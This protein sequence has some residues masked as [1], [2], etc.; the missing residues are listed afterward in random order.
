MDNTVWILERTDSERFPYRVTIKK[1]EEPLLCLLVQDR[2]PGQKGNI[3]CIRAEDTPESI[4]EE[5]ERVPVVSLKRFGK[6][7][8]VVLDRARN[9]RCDFLFLKKRYKTKEG[10]FEQIFWRT[11]QALKTRRPKVKLSTY[12]RSKPLNIIID[13]DE[14]Y[15]WTFAHNNVSREKLPVGDYALKDEHGILAVIERKT[16]DNMRAEFGRMAAFHQQLTE[17]EAYRYSA[18]VIEANYSDFLNPEKMTFYSP[19]FAAKAIAELHALH[20]GLTIVFAGNRKLAMQW[21]MSFF[22]AIVSQEEDTPHLK[23]AEVLEKYGTPPESRGGSYFEVRQKV[24]NE[25]SEV[26]SFSALREIF[27]DIPE[28]TIRRVLNDLKKEGALICTGR[29]KNARWQRLK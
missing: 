11:E 5:I 24:L 28:N 23:V 8:A 21:T 1:G 10:E 4:T 25:L 22:H 2:W 7:L 13:T 9:K 29:G 17:L 16:F 19:F 18:L 26:F 3:F 20:P 6:R 15:P 27:S 14:K 12:S